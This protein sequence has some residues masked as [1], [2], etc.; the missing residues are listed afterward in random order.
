M[1]L[2]PS[3]DDGHSSLCVNCKRQTKKNK[4]ELPLY[5]CWHRRGDR[6]GPLRFFILRFFFNSGSGLKA[7]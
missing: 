4:E 5:P 6:E 2:Q 3:R 7:K 1:G